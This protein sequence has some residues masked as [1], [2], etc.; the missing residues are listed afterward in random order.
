MHRE[1]LKLRLAEATFVRFV[2]Y[3]FPSYIHFILKGT[4]RN[5]SDIMIYDINA[6]QPNTLQMAYH[7]SKES[8]V[9]IC[10]RTYNNMHIFRHQDYFNDFYV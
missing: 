2:L 7:Y 3:L 5:M 9:C 10:I 1:N 4:K 8:Y 6:T